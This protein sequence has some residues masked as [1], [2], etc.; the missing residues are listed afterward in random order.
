ML[1]VLAYHCILFWNG[2][3]CVGES[4]YTAPVLSIVAQWMNIFHIY[5]VTL[6]SGYLF[7]YLKCEMIL[8]IVFYGIGFI[9][10]VILPNVFQIFHACTYLSLFWLGF[11]IRQYVSYYLKRIK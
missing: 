9:E 2:N 6:V 4:V 7:C 3:W 10:Q 8:A 5:A 11:K 1:I